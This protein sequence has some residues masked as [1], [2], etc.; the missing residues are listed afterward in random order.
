MCDCPELIW[1]NDGNWMIMSLFGLCFPNKIDMFKFRHSTHRQYL[2][3][4][5]AGMRNGCLALATKPPKSADLRDLAGKQEFFVEKGMPFLIRLHAADSVWPQLLA[6]AAIAPLQMVLPLVSF[7]DY[8]SAWTEMLIS[9]KEMLFRASPDDTK[10]QDI[11]PE[12]LAQRLHDMV[13]NVVAPG[14]PQDAAENDM[15]FLKIMSKNYTTILAASGNAELQT[16]LADKSA[17]LLA[18]FKNKVVPVFVPL[19]G[20]VQ[21]QFTTQLCLG[22]DALNNLK[23]KYPPTASNW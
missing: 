9:L 18:L 1:E 17:K 7:K 4:G 16:V 22:C 15:K 10:I 6:A 21:Q 13:S 8:L 3:L 2:D 23:T 11:N 20:Q 14:R 19:N 12:I 5:N